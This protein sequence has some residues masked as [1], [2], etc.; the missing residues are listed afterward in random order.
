[1]DEPQNC[2]IFTP[3]LIPEPDTLLLIISTLSAS[4]FDLNATLT[5]I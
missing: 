3:Y 4:F 2:I 1:L 5:R